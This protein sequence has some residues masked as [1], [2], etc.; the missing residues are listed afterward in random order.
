MMTNLLHGA[1]VANKLFSTIARLRLL[2]VMF[3]ALTVSAEVWGATW[4]HSFTST[5]S[6]GTKNW[7]NTSWTLTVNGGTTST[8]DN[9]K[10][11]HY[12][13]NNNTCT[14]VSFTTSNIPG[15]I[16]SIDVEASRGSSLV[17]TLSVSVG[18]QAYTLSSG[19]NALTTTNTKYT[20]T[21]NKSGDIAI[22]WNKASGKGAFYIKSISVTY[23]EATSVAVSGVSL[24]HST[25]SLE[26]GETSTLIATVLP[27]NAT[28]KNVTWS[29]SNASVATVRSDGVVAAVSAGSTTITVKTE[30]GDKT[31]TCN[32]TVSAP[33][34][35]GDD[36]DDGECTWQL[37]TNVSDLAVGDEIVITASTANYA[38]STTQRTSNR[39]AVAITKSDDAITINENVQVIT[40]ATASATKT[41]TF[42]FYVGTGFLYASSS[43]SNELKTTANPEQNGDWYLEIKNTGE[44]SI[45]AQGDKTRKVMQFNLNNNN[46][47]IFACYS[48]ASQ[49]SLAI[50]KK[51]CTA[52]PTVFVI[53]KCGGDG[54]GTW[55]VVIEW[56]ATF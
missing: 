23:K 28:N 6:G 33:A 32:V 16:S 14:S 49:T 5:E 15:T 24:N 44:A 43:G 18:G 38:L 40:L 17:G 54:G 42:A 13:T 31:E 51:V 56:F 47:A 19:S 12:G 37:V 35:G 8:Y 26:V 11:A 21:G 36:S 48:S 34:G 53:P 45:T 3:V 7:D 4:S 10:G 9:D 46:P 29:S 22:V 52:E 30:D 1:H 25:L 55:L 2:L 27:S 41:N 20:F 50:Y 39:Q